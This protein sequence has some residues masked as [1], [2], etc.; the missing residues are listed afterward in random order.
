VNCPRCGRELGVK[1]NLCTG[2][3]L[4]VGN[5]QA[6]PET[7]DGPTS[8][9]IEGFA[10]PGDLDGC[11]AI[12]AIPLLP[13]A[14]EWWI[15]KWR[16][17]QTRAQL[18]GEGVRITDRQLPQI[19]NLLQ[20]GARRLEIEC[21]ELFIRQ[22]PTFNAWTVG[23]NDCA[24]V[25]L[26]S[27]LLNDLEPEELSFVLSHELGHIKCRHV[28]YGSLARS[29]T[30]FMGALDIPFSKVLAAPLCSAITYWERQAEFTADRAGLV[31]S[32]DL[33]GSVRALVL[34]AL[35]S[36]K[37]LPIFNLPEYLSQAR[38]LEGFWGGFTEWAGCLGHPYT[39]KRTRS[40]IEFA[41]S[42]TGL[43]IFNH[44]ERKGLLARRTPTPKQLA[45]S[46]EARSNVVQAPTSFCSS[47]GF[48]LEPKDKTCLVCG[49]HN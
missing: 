39:V 7:R 48:Q 45:A 34:M 42:G 22:D 11:Q 9:T 8:L 40:I 2:C 27:A 4:F 20:A 5:S 14:I 32:A 12:E 38:E 24:V 18:L 31:G 47:C 36:R 10:V 26:H 17:P 16:L 43:A 19:Y 25:V 37:F 21:P 28:T 46:T 1:R 44:L 35:G 30:Q 49:E 29:L 41:A 23:T 13:L 33:Q 3:G 6:S 15:A